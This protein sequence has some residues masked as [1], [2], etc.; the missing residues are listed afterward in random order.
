MTAVSTAVA[1]RPNNAQPAQSIAL[2][3]GELTGFGFERL[4]HVLKRPVETVEP[5]SSRVRPTSSMSMPAA[6]SRTINLIHHGEHAVARGL[7]WSTWRRWHQA[8]ARRAHVRRHLQLQTL[9]I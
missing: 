9:M 4:Q 3:D 8:Q 5:W 6:R 2:P 1:S 7:E